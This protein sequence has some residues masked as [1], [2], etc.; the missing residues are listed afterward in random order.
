M[1]ESELLQQI[2]QGLPAKLQQH[3]D[4]LTAKLQAETISPTEHQ[5]L[6]ALIDQIELTNAERMKALIELAQLR[7]VSLEALMNQLG[8]HPPPPHG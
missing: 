3:Y 1:R 4:E 7:N 8:I 2:N 5:M 6:L